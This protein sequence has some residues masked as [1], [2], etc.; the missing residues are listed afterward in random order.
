VLPLPI[1]MSTAFALDPAVLRFEALQLSVA[2]QTMNG[3]LSVQNGSPWKLDGELAAA[4]IDLARWLPKSSPAKEAAGGKRRWLF[5]ETPL[6]WAALPQLPATLALKVQRLRLPDLPEVSALGTTLR[7]APGSL[8]LEALAFA[9]AGGRVDANLSLATGAAPPRLSLQLDARE[10]SVDALAAATGAQAYARG[11]R[12]R[13]SA[14]L[15]MAGASPRALAAGAGGEVLFEVSGTTLTGSSSIGPNLL[16]RLLQAI[17]LQKNVP[18][19]TVVQCAVVRLPLSHGVAAIDRSIAVETDLLELTA[20]GEVRLVD[21]TM[22]LAFKPHTKGL[23]SNTASLASLVVLKGPLSDPV[24]SI[25]AKGVAGMALSLGAAGVT[26][27]LSLLGQRLLHQA[28]DTQPCRFAATGKAAPA[29]PAAP[30]D[31]PPAKTPP[32]AKALPDLLPG[33]RRS[34]RG[35]LAAVGAKRR[36]P[37]ACRAAAF[38]SLRSGRDITGAKRRRQDSTSVSDERGGGQLGCGAKPRADLLPSA[39]SSSRE[40]PHAVK[41]SPRRMPKRSFS[42]RTS[43]PAAARATPS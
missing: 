23:G 19:Q 40:D 10:L 38:G 24:V 22:H 36:A 37:Q 29:A 17:S 42:A 39:R 26:G 5:D 35:R 8:K 7:S 18:T 1:E 28:A 25:D 13:L 2:G 41:I 11:G 9:L 6:P 16:P 3:R 27:G 31:A 33:G 15:D 20:S 4:S 21:E 14:R 43:L 34:A 30:A 32:P 12:A